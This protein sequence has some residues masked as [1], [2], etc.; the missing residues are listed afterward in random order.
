MSS[1]DRRTKAFQERVTLILNI[2]KAARM[3]GEDI[4]LNELLSLVGLER[5]KDML[6]DYLEYPPRIAITLMLE[7]EGWRDIV[8]LL[9]KTHVNK[10]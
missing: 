7:D 8:R 9:A 5:Y 2:L 6:K 3:E 1:Q 10:Y 4:T